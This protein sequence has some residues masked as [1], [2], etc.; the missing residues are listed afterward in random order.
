MHAC[1]RVFFV[2][3]RTHTHLHACQAAGAGSHLQS[4]HRHERGTPARLTARR[5]QEHS[6]RSS[7]AMC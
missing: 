3:A 7:A 4:M 6:S 2:T 1:C 5:V